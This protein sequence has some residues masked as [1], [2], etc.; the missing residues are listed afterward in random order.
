MR[1]VEIVNEANL[2][3]LAKCLFVAALVGAFGGSLQKIEPLVKVPL[4]RVID[5]DGRTYEVGYD[6]TAKQADDASLS[7]PRV[8]MQGQPRFALWGYEMQ[9][10]QVDLEVPQPIRSKFLYNPKLGQVSMLY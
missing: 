5:V 10:P 6:I 7:A 4:Q 9:G 1:E 3:L 2:T 8:K